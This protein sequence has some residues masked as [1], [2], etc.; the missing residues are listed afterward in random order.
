MSVPLPRVFVTVNIPLE[1]LSPL[2]GLA[3]IVMPDNGVAAAPRAQVLEM[4]SDCTA[5]LSQG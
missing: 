3:E 4:I 1:H 2:A 5:V